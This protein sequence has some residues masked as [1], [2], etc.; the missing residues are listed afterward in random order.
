MMD[1]IGLSKIPKYFI[2]RLISSATTFSFGDFTKTYTDILQ[3]E[4]G[5][6]HVRGSQI[7]LYSMHKDSKALANS[8]YQL[9][10]QTL[11]LFT[12]TDKNE[13][14]DIFEKALRVKRLQDSKLINKK[15]IFGLFSKLESTKANLYSYFWIQYGIASQ[16]KCR[17]D[18]ANNHFLKAQT[19]RNSYSVQH[20]LALNKFEKGYYQYIRHE[21]DAD[22]IFLQGQQEMEELIL[23]LN[24]PRTYSYSV[25]SY[26]NMLLKYYNK[27]R[28]IIPDETLEKMSSYIQSVLE[29]PLDSRMNKKISDFISYCRLH[30]KEKYIDDIKKVHRKVAIQLSE[31]DYDEILYQ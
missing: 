27:K 23:T 22:E 11:G 4:H 21:P 13:Y 10:V 2:N 26:V 30:H 20:A 28:N 7:L 16:R 12:E 3:V 29:S 8:L 19:I 14:S 15:E 5:Y 31:D 24:S 6:V 18:E 9:V 25:H 1:S 17:Y